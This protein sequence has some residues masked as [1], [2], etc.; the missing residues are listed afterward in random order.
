M[1]L[2]TCF[3]YLY[4]NYLTTLQTNTQNN[5]GFSHALLAAHAVWLNTQN[6]ARFGSQI[7]VAFGGLR[8]QN[9][10]PGA[11]SL[12]P[13]GDFH[14]P[15]SLCPLPPNPAYA[16]GHNAPSDTEKHCL[17]RDIDG[18]HAETEDG[19]FAKSLSDAQHEPASSIQRSAHE[20]AWK[21]QYIYRQRFN[22]L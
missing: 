2:I 1:Y 3:K 5:L 4:F 22:A 14:P 12:D 17:L 9:I 8:P 13:L 16:T 15:D 20:N 11:L 21:M 19:M 6:C 18:Y 10:P 7:S